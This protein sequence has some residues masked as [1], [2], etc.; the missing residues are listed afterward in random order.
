[1]TKQE[2]RTKAEVLMMG[3]VVKITSRAEAEFITDYVTKTLSASLSFSTTEP[4]GKKVVDKAFEFLQNEEP[5]IAYMSLVT[6]EDMPLIA[7]VIETKEEPS[8]DILSADG[9]FSYVY[10]MQVAYFSELGYTFYKKDKTGMIRRV[11]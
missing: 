7:Y 9:A 11:G 8:I 1:M 10:N 5:N 4:T 2:M 6:M 3:I